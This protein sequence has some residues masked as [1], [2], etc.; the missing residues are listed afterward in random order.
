M[1]KLLIFILLLVPWIASAQ[2]STRIRQGN[3]LPSTCSSGDIFNKTGTG[4][5]IYVCVAGTYVLQ[6]GGGGGGASNII[7]VT[8]P[9]Y[10]CD[11]TGATDTVPCE[12]AAWA[13]AQALGVPAVVFYP[14]GTYRHTTHGTNGDVEVNNPLL[15]SMAGDR[16]VIISN[17]TGSGNAFYYFSGVWSNSSITGMTMQNTHGVTTALTVGLTLGGGGSNNIRNLTISGN[18]FIDVARHIQFSGVDGMEITNNKFYMTHGRDSGTNDANPNVAVWGFNNTPNGTSSNIHMTGNVYDGCTSGNVSANTNKRCAD[19]M[20]YGQYS[21]GLVVSGNVIKRYSFE[22]M[23]VQRD[24]TGST[25]PSITG[26]YLD[27]SLVTGDVSGGGQYGIRCDTNYCTTDNNTII[28]NLQ[29]YLTYLPDYLPAADFVGLSVTNNHIYTTSTSTQ[30]FINAIAVYGVSNSAVSRNDIHFLGAPTTSTVQGILIEGTSTTPQYSKN[31]DASGNIIDVAWGTPP[32]LT[33]CLYIQFQDPTAWGNFTNNSCSSTGGTVTWVHQLNNLS[34]TA[35]QLTALVQNNT[36]TNVTTISNPAISGATNCKLVNS[37]NSSCGGAGSLSVQLDGT[38]VGSQPIM[39]FVT[40]N[41][42]TP[43]VTDTGTKINVQNS[44][45]T[46]KVFTISAFPTLAD[47]SPIAWNL[48]SQVV[49]NAAVTMAHA[50]GT[51]A[52]NITNPAIGGYYT[53]EALND[54]TGGATYTLGTGCTW[55]G[56]ITVSTAPNAVNT[57][58]FTYDGTNCTIIA[59]SVFHAGGSGTVTSVATTSPIGGGTI[60][61]TGTV[62]CTTCVVASSPGVGL[63]HFAGSTQTVTSSTVATADIAANAVTSAKMAVVNTYRT[64]DIPI[65]DTSGSA[66][67]SGQ[68][69]PQS[70][71]CFIPAAATIVE[72]DV[73]ADAGTPNIIVGR[74][75]AGT[76]ANI[77]SAALATAASG[78]IACSNAGGTTGLNGATTCSGTLQNTSLA[79]GD[80]LELVSGTPGGTAKFFVAHITYT[81]N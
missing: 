7:T 30:G 61:T 14:T 58:V 43:A 53:L 70:R 78:G 25:G 31:T 32:T 13:A 45:D 60:T 24:T 81:V 15:V 42:I 47:G 38:L 36:I 77:V 9:P 57:M 6:G 69:G 29:G 49:T 19:G 12:Q 51:R 35:T 72:M 55:V 65:G 54:G 79:A 56:S 27:G 74:N 80:Y 39:N 22:G 66:I 68:M 1:N 34:P 2:T 62:T 26:N 59:G 76:V 48:A 75:H 37:T 71:I 8:Q 23:F 17:Q 10:N 21:G 52:L 50:T 5:G 16:A 18:T 33:E 28:N 41:G 4:A 44:V 67:T 64:C 11:N 73:N 63:A 3:T 40:A 46:S 20:V